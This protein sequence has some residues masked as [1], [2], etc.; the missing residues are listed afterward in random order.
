M[1]SAGW[2]PQQRPELF[3]SGSMVEEEPGPLTRLNDF[4]RPDEG[5]F[6]IVL[7]VILAGIMG[8]SPTRAGSSGATS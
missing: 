7:V 2:L 1:A 3:R 6:G 5:F 4:L 8:H